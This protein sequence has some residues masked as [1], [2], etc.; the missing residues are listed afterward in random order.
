MS[1]QSEFESA[2]QCRTAEGGD[3]RLAEGL[4]ATQHLLEVFDGREFLF[5]IGRIGRTQ[6]VEVTPGEEGLLRRS[7]HD[8]G[9][10]IDVGFEPFHGRLEG[11][12]EVVVHGVDL[13]TGLVDDDGDDAIGI[14]GALV[15]GSCGFSVRHVRPFR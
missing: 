5:G 14:G 1:G 2:A 12:R 9:D 13:G 8:T 4:E 15:V 7:Q 3:D 11:G 6:L 10:V